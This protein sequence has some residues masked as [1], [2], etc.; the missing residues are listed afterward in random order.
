MLS[1]VRLV[2]AVLLVVLV[3]CA[4]TGD[5]SAGDGDDVAGAWAVATI[6]GDALIE[7]SAP[8][9]VLG[10]DGALSG[11]TGVNRMGGSWSRDGDALS[12][13]EVAMTRR[14]GRPELMDQETRLLEALG[15]TRGARIDGGALV[16][17]DADGAE[18][19]RATRKE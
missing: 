6:G 14:A 5:G 3:S 18:L 13:S 10:P 12:F 16:L 19:L 11:D 2:A 9:F 7:G 17:T 1:T 4:S 15:R 8:E